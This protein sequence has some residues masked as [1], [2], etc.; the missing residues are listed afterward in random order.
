MFPGFSVSIAGLKPKT[1]YTM[2]LDVVLADNHRFKFLN[3]RYVVYGMSHYAES[4][5]YMVYN[6]YTRYCIHSLH[7]FIN[8]PL[9]IGVS[10]CA[11]TREIIQWNDPPRKGQP[12]YK[13]HFPYPQKCII[14]QYIF[15]F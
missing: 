10:P 3:A 5:D 14:I 7:Y 9:K 12:L 11:V 8:Q 2:K 15:N 1:K 4:L 13:G 6:R